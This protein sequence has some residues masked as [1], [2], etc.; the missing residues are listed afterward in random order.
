MANQRS[1]GAKAVLIRC[2][3]SDGI[4]VATEQGAYVFVSDHWPRN[5]YAQD[6]LTAIC[7]HRSDGMWSYFETDLRWLGQCLEIAAGL[8]ESQVAA[9]ALWD[10]GEV[11][12][13]SVSVSAQAAA[14]L[15]T[16]MFAR[17]YEVPESMAKVV[18]QMNLFGGRVAA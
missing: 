1:K 18:V 9:M 13:T 15:A 3:S 12:Q 6:L 11:R 16:K 10:H 7:G 2:D 14:S 4:V 8:N 5:L 17:A